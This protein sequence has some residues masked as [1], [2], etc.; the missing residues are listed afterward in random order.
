MKMLHKKTIPPKQGRDQGTHTLALRA[1]QN[2]VYRDLTA[3]VV[4]MCDKFQN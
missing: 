4:V 2:V 1:S 3:K